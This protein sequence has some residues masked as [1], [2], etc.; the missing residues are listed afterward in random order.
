VIQGERQGQM[1]NYVVLGRVG[2]GAHGIVMKARHR[3]TGEVVALKKVALKPHNQQQQQRPEEGGAGG[4][5]GL[6]NETTIREIKALQELNSIH[7]IR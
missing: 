5:G 4:E 7:V 2:E 6:I 3:L 1:E